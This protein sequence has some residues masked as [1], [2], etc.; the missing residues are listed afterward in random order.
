MGQTLKSW[1]RV[2]YSRWT[3]AMP[4]FFKRVLWIACSLGA[5]AIGVQTAIQQGGVEPHEWWNDIYKVMLGISGGAMV[6]SKLTQK[7]DEHGQPVSH[8][9]EKEEK[10]N[11]VLDHDDF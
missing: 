3:N 1:W 4:R 6:V 5:I 2:L 9:K 7:Y 8:D 11:T 10:G